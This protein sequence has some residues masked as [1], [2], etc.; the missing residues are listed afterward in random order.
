RH[1][2]DAARYVRD[3]FDHFGTRTVTRPWGELTRWRLFDLPWEP[4]PLRSSSVDGRPGRVL[5]THGRDAAL[6]GHEELQAE[7]Y[8]VLS[9]YVQEGRANRLILMHGPNGSAKS[10]V[11]AC[12]LRALEHYSSL[13]EG[14]LYRFHWVF[15]SRK[16]MRGS[17]GFGGEVKASAAGASS[18]PLD[19][20]QIDARLVIELRDHPLFLIPVADRRA[21]L[22][23]LYTDAGAKEPPPE[24]LVSGKLSHKNQQVYEALLVSNNGSLAETLRHVQ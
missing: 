6:V 18:A 15:P 4:E 24:W 19:D 1:G 9:N 21:L 2:R 23:R 7:I 12:I 16:T 14:A 13:D 17:I 20:D 22:Q 8:R 5:S 11:A 3:M 10:T